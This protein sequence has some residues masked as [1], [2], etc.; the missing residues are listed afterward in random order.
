MTEEPTVLSHRTFT[1]PTYLWTLGC[2]VALLGYAIASHSTFL[3]MKSFFGVSD[4]LPNLPTSLRSNR[5][6]RN[7]S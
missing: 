3:Y 1:S 4:A 6:T 7:R 2:A 5:K